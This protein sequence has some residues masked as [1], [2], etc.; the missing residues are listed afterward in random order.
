M[1]AP[2]NDVYSRRLRPL[3]VE[4]SISGGT[5]S[6]P[7][8]EMPKHWRCEFDGWPP[9]AAAKELLFM[10]LC[11]CSIG[12]RNLDEVWNI[13]HGAEEEPEKFVAYKDRT[14]SRVSV[15]IVALGLLVS[16]S[17]TFVTTNPPTPDLFDYSRPAP[18]AC[19]LL[20]FGVTLGGVGVGAGQLFIL[21]HCSAQWVLNTAFS[22]RSRVCGTL[23]VLA[24]PT[25]S[26]SV[27]GMALAVGVLITAKDSSNASLRVGS[28]FLVIIP[29]LSLI[30]LLWTQ[31]YI[32]ARRSKKWIHIRLSRRSALTGEG[33]IRVH[34]PVP[35]TTQR[36]PELGLIAST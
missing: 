4:Q 2:P 22:T 27:S 13:V 3:T 26:L 5:S 19:I 8:A 28:V 6:P 24:Y 36:D 33:T 1:F 11:V 17:A 31:L 16:A 29:G 21:S 18:Y 25:W 34:M 30:I 14:G 12:S 35:D 32:I 20:S 23:V 7:L 10:A 9:Y 15:L